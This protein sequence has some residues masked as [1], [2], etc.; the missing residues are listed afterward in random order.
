MSVIQIEGGNQLCGELRV[1]GAKNSALPLLAASVLVSGVSIFRNCPELR[2]TA[3]AL[4]I[5]RHLGCKV[6]Q[7]GDTVAVDATGA[8]RSEIPDGLMRQMRSSVFF[9]G[10]ILA[11]CGEASLCLPGGCELGPRPV[12]LHVMA[13]RRLGAEVR[14]TPER[15]CCRTAGLTGAE[16]V[17][18][19]A[20]VG[21]TEN[22]LLAAVLAKG[23]TVI[24]GAAQEPEIADL[25]RFLGLA[26][27][28]IRG[29]GS[30]C[31]V[32]EGVSRLHGA[33]TAVLPDRIVAATYLCACAAAGGMVTLTEVVPAHVEAVLAVLA[34]AGCRIECGKNH[35]T[36]VS[37]GRLRAP[38]PIVTGPYPAFPTDAQPPLLAALLTAEGRSSLRETVFSDRFR[39]TGE[40]N[41]MGADV[42]VYGQLAEVYP[43]AA[44][45]GAAVTAPDLRG[46][47]ALLVAALGAEGMSRIAGL[48]HIDR[49]YEAPEM[50]LRQLGAQA[51]RIH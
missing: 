43:T 4:D 47:A 5:L 20:S 44:L 45:H 24:R 27:A 12:D 26:G 51:E 16:I 36:L 22:A 48:E 23:E 3:V 49:G 6:R 42:R 50:A 35:I 1:Q 41:R 8:I 40:L 28:K 39:Y 46:G 18:P 25:G 38:G 30:D 37:Q 15:L 7:Q 10:A 9:L 13:L 33:E 32:V 29:A 11:R 17:L 21:A 19:F 14:E 31:I 34:Q 2:D